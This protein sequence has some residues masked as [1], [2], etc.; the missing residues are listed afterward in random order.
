VGAFRAVRRP[1]AASFVKDFVVVKDFRRYSVG[2]PS[3]Q[4]KFT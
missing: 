1:G 2:N 4:Q 3:Q